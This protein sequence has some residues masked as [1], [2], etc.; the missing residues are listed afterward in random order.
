MQKA[1]QNLFLCLQANYLVPAL[2]TASYLSIFQADQQLPCLL[3]FLESFLDHDS[4]VTEHL[5]NLSC[6]YRQRALWFG[7][8]IHSDALNCEVNRVFI[9][10]DKAL[11]V[12]QKRLVKNILIHFSKSLIFCLISWTSFSFF[13]FSFQSSQHLCNS[14]V[15]AYWEYHLSNFLPGNS[16]TLTPTH[17]NLAFI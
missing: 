2:L 11:E 4:Q 12:S 9:S 8:H 7:F 16:F 13:F 15:W 14:S 3:H 6:S 10:P 17:Q 5:I 1:V